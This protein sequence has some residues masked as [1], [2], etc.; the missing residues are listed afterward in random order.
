MQEGIGAGVA[1][2]TAPMTIALVPAAILGG[3][4]HID[5]IGDQQ[6][7]QVILEVLAGLLVGKERIIGQG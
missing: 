6:L 3:P 1:A 5:Y 7:C 4:R 2:H